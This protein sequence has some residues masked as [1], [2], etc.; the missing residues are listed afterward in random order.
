M[1]HRDQVPETLLDVAFKVLLGAPTRQR[2]DFRNRHEW[3]LNS[4]LSLTLTKA[5]LGPDSLSS[6][7]RERYLE[8]NIPTHWLPGTIRIHEGNGRTNVK[9]L[10]STADLIGAPFCQ[11][12]TESL[13]VWGYAHDDRRVFS[14]H[15]YTQDVTGKVYHACL[16]VCTSLHPLYPAY[17]RLQALMNPA[18]VVSVV[19]KRDILVLWMLPRLIEV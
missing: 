18:P 19:S 16:V 1:R 17:K 5:I 8:G 4:I 13:R 14:T 11:W 2:A 10:A 12:G 15:W 6:G 3:S 7:Y 9:R